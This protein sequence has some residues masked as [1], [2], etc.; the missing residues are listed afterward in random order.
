[1]SISFEQVLAEQRLS[2]SDLECWI[3]ER[4]V[5]PLEQD[6]GFLFDE[7]DVARIRLIAELRNDLAVND[8]A[9]P[10]ILQLLDQVYELR[11]TLGELEQAIAGLPEASRSQL[12]SMI[13]SGSQS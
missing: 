11:R 8:E 3:R 2:R 1:M 6:G 13:R 9:V 10:L 4:W 12:D 7:V 5:L